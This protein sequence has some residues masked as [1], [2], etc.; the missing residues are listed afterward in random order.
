MKN[1]INKINTIILLSILLSAC[2]VSYPKIEENFYIKLGTLYRSY[3]N[4]KYENE[5]FSMAR[6]FLNKAKIID[7]GKVVGP[8]KISVIKNIFLPNYRSATLSEILNQRERMTL[9][10]QNKL[11]RTEYYE[12]GANLQFYFDCWV[13]EEQNYTKFGQIAKC[14]KSFLDTLEYLE[15]KL[16]NM[17]ENIWDEIQN[18]KISSRPLTKSKK[19]VVYFDFD[20]SLVN[21]EANRAIWKIIN[22]V[23]N[24]NQYAIKISGH[25]DTMG[26]PLYNQ[27]LSRRRIR[28]IRHYLIKNGIPENKIIDIKNEG[29]DDPRVITNDDFKEFLNRRVD[30][31][32]E[33]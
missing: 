20:S 9:I 12:D 32:V 10:I 29:Q 15:F 18:S 28:S 8:E 24:T 14:K 26:N 4:F 13:Y 33:K 5:D 1:I 30:V 17:T 31:I 3:G 22:Y 19:F 25:T 6:K 16:S 7:N 2:A 27:D 11:T 23:S 21:E